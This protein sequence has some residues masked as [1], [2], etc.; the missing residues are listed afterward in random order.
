MEWGRFIFLRFLGWGQASTGMGCCTFMLTMQGP[1]SLDWG[2]NAVS[3]LVHFLHICWCCPWNYSKGVSLE[4]LQN[5]IPYVLPQRFGGLTNSSVCEYSILTLITLIISLDSKKQI[6][7]CSH[8]L[9][10]EAFGW[11]S[12]ASFCLVISPKCLKNLAAV[13]CFRNC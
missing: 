10:S 5:C 13:F 4:V 8:P 2:D 1:L 12:H 3:D 9:E 7:Y 11:K 6:S